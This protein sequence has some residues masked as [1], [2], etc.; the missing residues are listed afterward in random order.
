MLPYA[1]VEAGV[2][3]PGANGSGLRAVQLRHRWY[4]QFLFRQVG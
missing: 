3:K 2:C 1:R 4:H